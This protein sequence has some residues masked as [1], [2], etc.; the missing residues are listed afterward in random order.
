MVLTKAFNPNKIKFK[1]TLVK[2]NVIIS[3][4]STLLIIKKKKEEKQ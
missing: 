1:V 4:I 2:L 3:N